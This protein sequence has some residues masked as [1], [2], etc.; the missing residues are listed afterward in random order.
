M[1]NWYATGVAQLKLLYFGRAVAGRQ[2]LV[3]N[4]LRLLVNVLF[5][6]SCAT[7]FNDPQLLDNNVWIGV[8]AEELQ[9]QG[10]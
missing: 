6:A 7:T 2:G 5:V 3:Q 1:L 8:L 4:S 9:L 10:V